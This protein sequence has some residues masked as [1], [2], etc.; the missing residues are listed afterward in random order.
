MAVNQSD[1]PED[2]NL[3]HGT[4]RKGALFLQ[5]KGT[6]A[7]FDLHCPECALHSHFDVDFAYAVRCPG[8][9]RTWVM[10]TQ[11]DVVAAEEIGYSGCVQ[12]TETDDYMGDPVTTPDG[13]PLIGSG[14]F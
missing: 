5:W 13:T 10:Q 12:E 6:D 7:C 3:Q 11:L 4:R 8:C 2:V 14:G 1:E 9:G